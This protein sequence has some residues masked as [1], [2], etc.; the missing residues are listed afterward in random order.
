[1]QAE[2]DLLEALKVSADR[3]K[4]ARAEFD[5]LDKSKLRAVMYREQGFICVFCEQRVTEDEKPPIDH[6][7]PLALNPELALHWKNLHVSC[8][9]PGT[10]DDAKGGRAL[11]VNTGDADLP[12]PADFDYDRHIGF[13]RRGELFVRTD[14]ALDATTRETLRLAIE[15]EPDARGDAQSIL[16]LNHPALVAA[17]KAAIDSER[18]RL[19]RDFDDATATVDDRE[20]RAKHL[21]E[22]DPLPP[23]V[24]IRVLW[25]RKQLGKGK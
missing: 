6:W 21:L 20:D 11:K 10:C 22:Q 9:F 15:H 2:A 4:T 5:R 17:R 1:V 25:L 14:T 19:E 7:R 23:F 18:T 8:P 3:V 13:G 16:N 24:S 12:W